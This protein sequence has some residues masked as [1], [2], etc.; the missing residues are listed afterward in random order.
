MPGFIVKYGSDPGKMI[1]M[2]S[3]RLLFGRADDCDVVVDDPNVSRHH[4][5][6]LLLNG[7]VMLVDLNS[8]NGTLVNELPISRIFLSDGDEIR[9]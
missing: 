2:N 7:L 6:A 1:P 8:S 5:S 4:A 9:L 3:Q